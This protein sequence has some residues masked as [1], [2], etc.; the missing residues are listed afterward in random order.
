MLEEFF[1][2]LK[3][4]IHET[5]GHPTLDLSWVAKFLF[6]SIF[7]YEKYNQLRNFFTILSQSLD[8]N[9]HAIFVLHVCMA[10]YGKSKRVYQSWEELKKSNLGS[11][12]GP[13]LAQC[14]KVGQYCLGCLYESYIITSN[15]KAEK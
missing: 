2:K 11:S 8:L 14:A 13:R 10:Y 1:I 3:F 5:L 9:H 7:F 15:F 4:R 6:H 12:I